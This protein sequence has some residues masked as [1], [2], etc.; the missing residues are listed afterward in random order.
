[1]LENQ[2]FALQEPAS[3]AILQLKHAVTSQTALTAQ[4]AFLN[5]SS[6]QTERTQFECSWSTDYFRIA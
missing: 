6:A 2:V 1:M 4:T 3:P 5:N